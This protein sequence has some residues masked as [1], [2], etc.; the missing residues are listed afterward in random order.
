MEA[1]INNSRP[2]W[3]AAGRRQPAPDDPDYLGSRGLSRGLQRAIDLELKGKKGLRIL[4]VG[5]GQK[6]FYPFFEPF[7]KTYIGTD[8]LRG[9]SLIDIVCPAESLAVKDEWADLVLCLSVLEHVNNPG[10]VVGELYRVVK[11]GGLVFA[12]THG[13]FPWHPYPQ[14]HWRWTQTGLPLL[15][16]QHAAFSSVHLFSTRG[17]MSGIFFLLAHYSYRW[18]SE[19]GKLFLRRP[20]TTLINRLGEFLDRKS[21]GLADINRPVTAIP[22]FFVI[23]K[24]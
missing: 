2:D 8:I 14:D 21:P 19:K 24:K 12:S 23:A 20:L 6:A 7:C 4:D 16:K 22:E 11:Q 5:C 15:F 18:T 17:S 13:C 10:N 1:A 9:D 3:P